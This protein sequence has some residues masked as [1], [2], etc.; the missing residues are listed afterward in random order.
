MG[1]AARILT[2]SLKACISTEHTLEYVSLCQPTLHELHVV[3]Q[4]MQASRSQIPNATCGVVAVVGLPCRLFLLEGLP[5][6][7]TGIAMA[8]TLPRDFQ[9]CNFLSNSVSLQAALSHESPVLGMLGER[10][11]H[12]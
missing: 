10:V 1:V 12:R 3:H 8:Y 2:A 11:Q 6:V 9:S 7:A 4:S 5:S